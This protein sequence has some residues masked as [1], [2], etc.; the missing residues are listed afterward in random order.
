M[1]NKFKLCLAIF[2]CMLSANSVN[3]KSIFIFTSE[4]VSENEVS[5]TFK[6]YERANGYK[7]KIYS[8]QPKYKRVWVTKHLYYDKK[9]G[10][11][12]VEGGNTSATFGTHNKNDK[13]SDSLNVSK[14]DKTFKVKVKVRYK[15]SNGKNARSGWKERIVLRSIT[16]D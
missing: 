9:V 8:K 2:I 4:H 7:M 11:K 3:N 1:K 5:V 16:H 14:K 12:W 10:T 15:K 6:C 13:F